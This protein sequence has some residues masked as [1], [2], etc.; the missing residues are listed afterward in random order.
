MSQSWTA[1]SYR[2]DH[3]G[4][5][6]LQNMENNFAA[7]KSMFSGAGAPSNAEAGMPWFDTGQSI[8]KI[9]NAGN[10]AWLGVMYG[11]VNQKIPVYRN[12][13]P[14]GWAID[15][16]VTDRIIA[17]KGG[18]AAYNTNAG[19]VAGTWSQGT[20][21]HT[22]TH[23]HTVPVHN[24]KYS[25]KEGAPYYRHKTYDSGGSLIDPSLSTSQYGNIIQTTF[26]FDS[27][28][29]RDGLGDSY[30]A[31]VSSTVSGSSAA[32]VGANGTISTW[33]PAA[34]VCTLQYPDV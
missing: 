13:A 17:L 16:S 24:H 10:S 8:L 27:F 34:A 14:D 28:T 7:L 33:R 19:A 32:N 30:T 5:T 12:S 26:A 6:D 25:H 9:R 20:H 1:D 18:T 3:V 21:I 29:S 15:S 22:M 23:N 2:Y 11:D 4:T 31:N